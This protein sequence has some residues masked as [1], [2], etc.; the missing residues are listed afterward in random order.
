MGFLPVTEGRTHMVRAG[1]RFE[2]SFRKTALSRAVT[3]WLVALSLLVQGLVPLGQALA[4]E[5]G[6]GDNFQVICTAQGVKTI[7]VDENGQ[8]TDP[9]EAVSCPFCLVHASAVGIAPQDNLSLSFPHETLKASFGVVR[10][11]RHANLWHA[12]PRMP[13][14]PPLSV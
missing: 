11:D 7:A 8:P 2:R 1:T 14:G 13:R 5:E 9:K 3:A 4:A 6:F 10:T 12:R